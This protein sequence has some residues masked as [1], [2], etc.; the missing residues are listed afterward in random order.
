MMDLSR[1]IKGF[2][3]IELL[4]VISI[5][6]LLLAILIPSLQKARELANTVVCSSRLKQLGLGFSFYIENY[7]Y[8][9][10]NDRLNG[11][12]ITTNRFPVWM[13]QLGINKRG[14]I[15]LN[16][17]QTVLP[18][19][20]SINER[21]ASDTYEKL[22]EYAYKKFSCPSFKPPAW[23]SYTQNNDIAGKRYLKIKHPS[24]TVMALDVGIANDGGVYPQMWISSDHHADTPDRIGKRH[25]KGDGFNVLF[26]DSSVSRKRE[27]D[28]YK[29]VW[30]H[31]GAMKRS[32]RKN[33]L[34]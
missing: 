11:E 23:I 25:P 4:V 14:I 3:L 16:W 26:A 17:R 6:T 27:N 19:M 7:K 15:C 20:M 34:P 10:P 8:V 28:I 9:P 18:L 2:T 32:G 21:T 1:R 30:R 12:L 33:S 31:D 22:W 13:N 24:R 5:I 29:M